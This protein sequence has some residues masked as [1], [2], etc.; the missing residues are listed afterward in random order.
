MCVKLRARID[1]EEGAAAV[2]FALVAILLF[3]VLFAIINFGLVLHR[4]QVYEG[5]AREGRWRAL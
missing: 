1:D 3:S 4:Y 2:E 5:A